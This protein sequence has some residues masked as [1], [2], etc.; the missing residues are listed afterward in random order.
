[1]AGIEEE[2]LWILVGGSKF[3]AVD[4]MSAGED[5]VGRDEDTRPDSGLWCLNL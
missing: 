5:Q 2:L 3:I 1:M 4:V